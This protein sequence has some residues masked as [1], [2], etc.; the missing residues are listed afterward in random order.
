MTLTGASEGKRGAMSERQYF[1]YFHQHVGQSHG[2]D[3]E[4][5]RLAEHLGSAE[6]MNFVSDALLD[7]FGDLVDRQSIGIRQCRF[8]YFHS[9]DDNSPAA[10]RWMVAA[11]IHRLS[12]HHAQEMLALSS[13]FLTHACQYF[14]GGDIHLHCERT[15]PCTGTSLDRHKLHI[16][17]QARVS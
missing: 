2:G 7:D 12:A 1:V 11:R 16:A 10:L 5:L 13:G 3:V 4:P 8:P 6:E 17:Q 14:D 9:H 15:V